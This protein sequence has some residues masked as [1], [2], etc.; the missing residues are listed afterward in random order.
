MY[1]LD[2]DSIERF[3]VIFIFTV[4]LCRI[5]MGCFT[6]IFVSHTCGENECT[7]DEKFY[8]TEISA[9]I[10]LILNCISFISF[11]ILYSMELYRENWLIEYLDK[12]IDLPE[13]DLE[14][15]LP[16]ELKK[17]LMKLNKRYYSI[18]SITLILFVINV[19]SCGIF[20]SQ[21]YHS[22]STATTFVSFTLLLLQKVYYSYNI[23]KLDK[24][25][26]SAH[27]SF[28]T[29]PYIFNTVDKDYKSF[30]IHGNSCAV[31]PISV[32]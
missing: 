18:S 7:L 27:S 30:T 29:I 16:L 1:L 32:I 17:E 22:F 25:K 6:S 9:I 4:E 2:R 3:E 12:K 20:L 31:H 26:C 13:N 19:L 21:S 11:V 15:H 5:G 28:L 24:G 14:N 23:S 8:P 10:I